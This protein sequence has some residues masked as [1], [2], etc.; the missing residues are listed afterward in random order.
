[1]EC[2]LSIARLFVRGGGEEAWALVPADLY[3]EL[4]KKTWY[5]HAARKC[6]YVRSWD[7]GHKREYLHHAVKRLRRRRQPTKDHVVRHLSGDTFDNTDRN[8]RWGTRRRNL[9]DKPYATRP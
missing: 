7:S 4:V 6:V 1:M 8:L 9:K 2:P 5:V 3:P